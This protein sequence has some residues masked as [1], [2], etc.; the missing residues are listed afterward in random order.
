MIFL[1][2]GAANADAKSNKVRGYISGIE[3]EDV[4]FVEDIRIVLDK[5]IF[6]EFAAAGETHTYEYT[7]ADLRVGT[8]VDVR[9]NF[10]D[11]RGNFVDVRGNRIFASESILAE[12][13]II[14]AEDY[15]KIKR[16][17]LIERE[18]HLEKIGNTWSG[19][20]FADGQRI[21]VMPSTKVLYQPN[22]SERKA[23]REIERLNKSRE[24][25]VQKDKSPS[26]ELD[27]DE[28]N[29]ELLQSFDQI[30]P[31]MFMTYEGIRSEDG[32]IMAES[33]TFKRNE[34]TWNEA[35]WK[36]ML[37]PRIKEPV[38]EDN[39]PGRI[40]VPWAGS[41]RLVPSRE[42]QEYIQRL[43][44]SLIPRYQKDMPDDHPDKIQFHFYLVK[45]LAPNAFALPNGIIVVMAP[46]LNPDIS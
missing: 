7:L 14:Y 22:K 42:A 5:D 37:T 36:K 41:F 34:L 3:A 9:G 30:G 18:P 38:Y 43:G 6:A 29:V 12:S 10:V 35:R 16:T 45:A 8:F 27:S 15:K 17:A 1:Y 25:A 31:N 20:F 28:P 4:F 11:V 19:D 44:N 13:I 24:R 26:M 33:L 39:K 2:L 40:T 21:R 32:S 46:L 23:Q